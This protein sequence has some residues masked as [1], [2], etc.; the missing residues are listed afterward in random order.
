M[1]P[2]KIHYGRNHKAYC[3][4]MACKICP[5]L[6]FQDRLAAQFHISMV[7]FKQCFRNQSTNE[8]VGTSNQVKQESPIEPQYVIVHHTSCYP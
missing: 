8:P 5:N 2:F 3:S 6:V 1:I 4:H 7:H